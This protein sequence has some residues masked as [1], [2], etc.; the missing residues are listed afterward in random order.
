MVVDVGLATKET[1]LHVSVSAF[2]FSLYFPVINLRILNNT[3]S[4]M[5]C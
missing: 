3:V 2:V 5:F 4:A 1:G